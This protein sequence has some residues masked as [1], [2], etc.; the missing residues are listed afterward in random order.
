VSIEDRATPVVVLKAYA[1]GALGIVRSLGRLGVRVHVIDSHPRAPT[2]SSRYCQGKFVYDLDNLPAEK[3][4]TAV[5]DVGQRIGQRSILIPTNDDVAM[6]VADHADALKQ[7]FIFPDQPSQLV[8]SL[9]SKKEMY[10]L[11][12]KLGLPTAKAAFPHSRAE[13]SSFLKGAVFPIMLKG[14]DGERLWRRTG[15]K[16]F[17]VRSES[18]LLDKYDRVEDPENPNLMLQE[19]IPGSDDSVWMFNGYFN[20]RSE[21]LLAFTGRKIRQ[22]PIHTGSTSLGICLRNE[23]VEKT[24]K[25]FMKKIGYKGILD[26]GY[27]YDARDGI[28]KVLD[29]NPRIGSTFRLFVAENGMDVARALYL[30]LTGQAVIPGLAP[31]GRKWIVEDLD[32]VSCF[33]YHRDGKLTVGEWLRSFRGIQEAA[34]FAPDD[35]LPILPMWVDRVGEGLRRIYTGHLC[36]SV[37]PTTTPHTT[38]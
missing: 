17:I 21:C 10:G 18:E 5:L 7:W 2:F 26:I 25:E 28:Y 23:I 29:I 9:C 31:E 3:L 36:P 38:P 35:L 33:R 15:K 37:Y 27:R 16:M 4:L 24:T 11:A 20:E 6:F 32:L 8:H 19:Y 13:V 1:H 14:V 30:D 34:Y 22:C 12:K